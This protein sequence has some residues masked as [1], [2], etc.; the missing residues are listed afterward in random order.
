MNARS[1]TRTSVHPQLRTRLRELTADTILEAAEHVF[2]ELGPAAGMDAIATKAGVAVGTLYNHF[3][4]R[5]AL[6]DAL[7]EARAT[8][9]LDRVRREIADSEG[10]RFRP[11]LTR[12]LEAVLAST[13]PNPRFRQVFLQAEVRKPRRSAVLERLRGVLAPL[14]EQGQRESALRR[15]PYRLQAAFLLAQLHTALVIAHDQPNV[16]PRDK[17]VEV[18][19]QQFLDGARSTTE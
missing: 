8:V 17:V 5:D 19:M 7:F 18:V 4:D 3:R 1:R 16:L 14:V 9:L 10:E 11:R 6:V 12:V 13:S 15:D 2:A